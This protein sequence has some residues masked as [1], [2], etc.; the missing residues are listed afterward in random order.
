MSYVS[1]GKTELADIEDI[2]NRTG[3]GEIVV[4]NV[5]F[6]AAGNEVTVDIPSPYGQDKPVPVS[7]RAQIIQGNRRS[8]IRAGSTD[9]TWETAYFVSDTDNVYADI[10]IIY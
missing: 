10:A 5:H 8:I 6:P 3:L 2:L 9:W 1:T 7:Y 4:R